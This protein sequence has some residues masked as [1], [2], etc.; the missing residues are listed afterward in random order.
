M[1]DFKNPWI[2]WK[3]IWECINGFIVFNMII[4]WFD[5][6]LLQIKISCTAVANMIHFYSYWYLHKRF[7]SYL[8]MTSTREFLELSRQFTTYFSA[9]NGL[10]TVSNWFATDVFV[11]ITGFW[12]F[13]RHTTKWSVRTPYIFALAFQFNQIRNDWWYHGIK[14]LSKKSKL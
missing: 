12:R 11:A 8:P 1:F 14:S 2:K 6:I 9:W 3:M 4:G 5:Q 13:P 10:Q 7:V